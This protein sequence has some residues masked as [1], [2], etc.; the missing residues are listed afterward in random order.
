MKKSH[1]EAAQDGQAFEAEYR[2]A[3]LKSGL[4]LAD[5]EHLVKIYPDHTK[6]AA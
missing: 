5:F 3:G 4:S 1:Q 2:T 6:D